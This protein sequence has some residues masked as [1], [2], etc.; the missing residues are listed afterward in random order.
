MTSYNALLL[1][2]SAIELI[3]FLMLCLPVVLILRLL[4]MF[5]E[6]IVLYNMPLKQQHRDILNKDFPY[7]RKLPKDGVRRFERK[8]I[9][10]MYKKKFE[11]RK[12]LEIT[13]RM[14]VLISASAAQLTYGLRDLRFTYFGTI[15]IFPRRYMNNRTKRMH[16]GEVNMREGMIVIS[17]EDALKGIKNPK[18]GRN[19]LL[20]EMAH[21]LRL[22]DI[23]SNDEY[24]FL[25]ERYVKEFDKAAE[26]IVRQGGGSSIRGLFRKYALT[27]K[28]EFFAVAVEVFFERPAEFRVRIPDLYAMMSKLLNQDPASM[29]EAA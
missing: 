19:L 27:N 13:D 4:Y 24:K 3:I 10:F 22:E 15:T 17:W 6:A 29:Y 18:D 7:Y 2:S 14:L 23:I 28:D 8:L 16:E 11:G 12:K 9:F 26:K 1:S 5:F 25:K 20:H 21:A